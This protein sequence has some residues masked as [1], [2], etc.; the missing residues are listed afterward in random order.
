MDEPVQALRAHRQGNDKASVVPVLPRADG[1]DEI[2]LSTRRAEGGSADT[3]RSA[4]HC[5]AGRRLVGR[6]WELCSCP[7]ARAHR[8]QL[9]EAAAGGRAMLRALAAG[10]VR[11]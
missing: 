6:R 3:D 2:E 7:E 11:L 8:A 10:S 4:R 1:P 9:I 5:W